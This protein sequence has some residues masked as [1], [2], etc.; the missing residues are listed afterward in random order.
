MKKMISM[1]IGCI[2]ALFLYGC[3]ASQGTTGNNTTSNGLE[4]VDSSQAL[5]DEIAAQHAQFGKQYCEATTEDDFA[6]NS[7]LIILYPFA[8]ERQYMPSDFPNIGCT[9]VVD[10]NMSSWDATKPSRLI[11]LTI[12]NNSK[13]DVLAAIKVLELRDDIFAAYPDYRMSLP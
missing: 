10:I 4:S 11:R 13:E 7:I 8:M 5:M 6:E 3:A 2:I 12:N 9:E 1:C